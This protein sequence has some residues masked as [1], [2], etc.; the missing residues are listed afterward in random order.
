MRHLPTVGLIV[1]PASGAIPPEPPVLYGRE[2][3]FLSAGLG[4]EKMTPEGY[5]A[6]IDRTGEL[7]RRLVAD[8]ADA[9]IMMG[10]SLSFYRGPT[11]NDELV[12]IMEAAG[13]RPATT[14]SN[15]IVEALRAVGASRIAVATAYVEAVNQRLADFLRFAGFEVAVLDSLDIER[16][17][18]V[19]S[20]G[21]GRL[22]EIGVRAGT[23][24]PVDALLL[25]CGGLQTLGV[26]VPLE[27]E[28]G[29]PVI[30]SAMAGAWAAARLVGHSGASPSFG[31]LFESTG[32]D[33][34]PRC[35]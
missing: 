14:M 26:T 17:E 6:V 16:V 25:S 8:G 13:G 1:P 4:L 28:L 3:R 34:L 32:R 29:I 5:E 21:A 18:D 33:L 35:T 20:V 22:M 24:Q 30:S 11:F 23:A 9:V 10:T 2:V 15:A 19:P 12:H 7:A 31:R 27:C